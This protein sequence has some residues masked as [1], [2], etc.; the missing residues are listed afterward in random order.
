MQYMRISNDVRAAVRDIALC[1]STDRQSK[2]ESYQASL[3]EIWK[4]ETPD[5]YTPTVTI[6][7]GSEEISITVTLERRNDLPNIVKAFGFPPEKINAVQ[8]R[9][10]A[11]N[12]T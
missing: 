12:N 3:V 8:Y 5:L 10:K 4:E 6:D 2:I 11:E 7:N 9:M 1:A